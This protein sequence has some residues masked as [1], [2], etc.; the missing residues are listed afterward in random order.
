VCP[1]ST[2]R[3]LQSWQSTQSFHTRR[4]AL[5]RRSFGGGA[6]TVS[7]SLLRFSKS[8]Y[9]KTLFFRCITAGR[10]SVRRISARFSHPTTDLRPNHSE[11]P[12][13]GMARIS[14]APMAVSA[15]DPTSL[16]LDGTH[17]SSLPAPP[18]PPRSPQPPSQSRQ[19]VAQ[20]ANFSNDAA[21]DHPQCL[22][23]PEKAGGGAMGVEEMTLPLPSSHPISATIDH[24]TTLWGKEP[25]PVNM[26]E[27]SPGIHQQSPS[28]PPE[29]RRAS[30]ASSGWVRYSSTTFS[31]AHE[32]SIASSDLRHKSTY[33]WRVL[34]IN[35]A[36]PFFQPPQY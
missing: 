15:S 29:S 13:P 27:K 18:A 12:E 8:I 9:D 33:V 16:T 28:S 23:D 22:R 1:P 3:L 26:T 34:V 31:S 30:S 2:H 4:L 24:K 7:F 25:Q 6:N 17:H 19:S 20:N 35:S 14:A 10:L 21:Q 32:R 5:H 11:G 36:Q